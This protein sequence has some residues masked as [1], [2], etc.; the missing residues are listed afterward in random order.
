VFTNWLSVAIFAAALASGLIAGI[1]FAFSSFVMKALS[2]LPPHHG[3][4]AMQSINAAVLNPAFLGVFVGTALVSA[5]LAIPAFLP[6]AGGSARYL[7]AGSVLYIFGCFLVTGL[8]NVPLNNALA[9][10][11]PGTS[12]A[13]GVWAV[14]LRRWLLW[15]H[16]RTAASLAAS[17]AF[18]LALK[19][20]T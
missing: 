7:L 20:A 8:C 6:S 11:E 19:A 16:V 1:F 2:R 17:G 3:I 10:V 5:A 13:A 4:A 14:Y 12:A 9:A 18:L 15:N